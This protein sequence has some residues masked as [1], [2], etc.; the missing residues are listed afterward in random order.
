MWRKWILYD[1]WQR[2]AQWLDQE[3]APKLFPKLNLHQKK[4]RVPVWWS[5]ACLI[6]YSFLNPGQTIAPEKY[7]NWWEVPKTSMPVVSIGR[8]NGPSSSPQ[9]WPLHVAQPMLQKLN[10]FGYKVL[11]HLPSSPDLLP[12]NHHSKHRSSF[13][14]GKGFHSQQEQKMLSKSLLNPKAWIFMLQEQTGLILVGKNV[15]I[16][17]VPTLI[18]MCWSLVIMI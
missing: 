3:E 5:A 12:T 11:P 1:H 7:A 13:V 16:V 18:K 2:P 15:L 8:Q 9:Q 10:E 4:V 6:Y 17:V 14:Q